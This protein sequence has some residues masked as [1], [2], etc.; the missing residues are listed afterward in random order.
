MKSEKN[1][2]FVRH[3]S[4][5]A[6]ALACREPVIWTHLKNR[7]ARFAD[8]FDV[9]DLG[10][11]H[12][13][14][15]KRF[16][17]NRLASVTAVEHDD[18]AI[19]LLSKDTRINTVHSDIV[20]FIGQADH[21]YS[22]IL[23]SHVS[24]YFSIDRFAQLIGDCERLLAKDG[25]IFIVSNSVKTIERIGIDRSLIRGDALDHT[26]RWGARSFI[27]DIDFKNIES[28]NLRIISGDRISYNVDIS[29]IRDEFLRFYFRNGAFSAD[30]RV[31]DEIVFFDRIVELGN[32][33]YR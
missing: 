32:R 7:T 13:P 19:E 22:I 11:G 33:L 14:Y 10:A 3:T 26:G 4:T 25:A 31:P 16:A 6:K 27:E 12:G 17:E 29:K 9:L 18:A 24:Y 1:P 23:L 20:E 2:G 21:E 30:E 8:G 15:A 28:G 5:A